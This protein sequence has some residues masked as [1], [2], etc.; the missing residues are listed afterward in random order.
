MS[1]T[2]IP[3]TIL[4]DTTVSQRLN[5]L[6]PFGSLAEVHDNPTVTNRT[7]TMRTTSVLCLGP[8][9]NQRGTY[10][11]FSLEMGRILRRY[12]Q[13]DMPFTPSTADRVHHMADCNRQINRLKFRDR[14]NRVMERLAPDALD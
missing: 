1:R 12:E 7:R 13:T 11:F 3:R 6:L 2:Y 10:Q 9:G 4:L 8:M 14:T 5:C